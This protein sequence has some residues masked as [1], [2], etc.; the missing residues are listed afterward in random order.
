M[1]LKVKKSRVK[2]L[3]EKD[4]IVFLKGKTVKSKHSILQ[5]NSILEV[6]YYTKNVNSDIYFYDKEDSSIIG[7]LTSVS[8][9]VYFMTYSKNVII[10]EREV[11]CTNY[12]RALKRISKQIDSRFKNR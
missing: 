3:N 1:Y 2:F 4:V 9:K 10:Y 7:Y 11:T 12:E 8:G 6:D 5:M